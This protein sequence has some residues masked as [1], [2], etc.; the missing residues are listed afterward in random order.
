MKLLD[1][2]TLKIFSFINIILS[3]VLWLLVFKW[4]D[5]N[6]VYTKLNWAIND[7]NFSIGII[8]VTTLIII[9]SIKCVFSHS[10]DKEKI[11]KKEGIILEN[12]DGKLLITKQTLESIISTVAKGFNGAENV[13]SNV[14]VDAE[15]NLGVYVTLFVHPNAVIKDLS[16]NL[17]TKIKEA[18]K[19][20][21]D[22]EVKEINIEVKN[23]I[24]EKTIIEQ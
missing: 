14:Y 7:N 20:T 17:Q 9:L 18:I 2:I 24:P 19:K 6:M 22:L 11:R 12:G 23:I 21:A 15:N 10:N 3:I 16:S 8:V 4:L 5:L 1:E 13:S